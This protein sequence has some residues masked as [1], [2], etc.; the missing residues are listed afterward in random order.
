MPL[1]LPFGSAQAP[2]AVR[3]PTIEGNFVARAGVNDP[4]FAKEQTR[5]LEGSAAIDACD[6]T[7]SVAEDIDG[8]D[9][10]QGAGCDVGADEL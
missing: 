5:L 3:V 4:G 6:G 1:S 7:R 2:A 10:P 8:D 9:R